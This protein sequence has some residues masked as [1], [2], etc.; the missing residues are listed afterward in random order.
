[1]GIL[2]GNGSGPEWKQGSSLASW[3]L[4]GFE[5]GGF[6]S[7]GERYFFDKQIP[8]NWRCKRASQLHRTC[9][10]F[11]LIVY[12]A[13]SRPF[14]TVCLLGGFCLHLNGC[15]S[16]E[17]LHNTWLIFWRNAWQVLTGVWVATF[18][19]GLCLFCS[20]MPLTLTQTFRLHHKKSVNGCVCWLFF[21]FFLMQISMAYSWPRRD[22][23][24]DSKL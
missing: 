13:R 15:S 14:F 19:M 21:F 7:Q 22:A 11:M 10:K 1:M 24:S 4:S 12:Q 16:F 5:R 17:D 20:S 2:R 18:S 6:G 9:H 8:V 3:L 23:S